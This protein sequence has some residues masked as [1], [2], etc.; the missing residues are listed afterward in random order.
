MLVFGAV[1]IG[2]LRGTVF[3]KGR[4]TEEGRGESEERRRSQG[5]RLPGAYG[6]QEICQRG[7][8]SRPSATCGGVRRDCDWRVSCGDDIGVEPT[9]PVAPTQAPGGRPV[10][11]RRAIDSEGAGEGGVE[12][13]LEFPDLGF[14]GYISEVIVELRQH[15]RFPQLEQVAGGAGE[16]RIVCVPVVQQGAGGGRD[17]IVGEIGFFLILIILRIE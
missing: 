10:S 8:R 13:T 17:D 6:T 12:R 9:G 11:A 4:S 2:S 14:E 3:W 1:P 15:I 7:L 5:R 16:S